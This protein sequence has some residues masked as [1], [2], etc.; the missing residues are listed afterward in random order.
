[1]IFGKG[2]CNVIIRNL[3]RE[4]D[5]TMKKHKCLE[6]SFLGIL[7]V[8]NERVIFMKIVE[9]CLKVPEYYSSFL[10]EF[11][12]I[13]HDQRYVG[14]F[15]FNFWRPH[16]GKMTITWVIRIQLRQF[17]M[18]RKANRN[19]YNL[20]EDTKSQFRGFKEKNLR[21]DVKQGQPAVE[22]PSLYAPVASCPNREWEW[23][24]SRM[25]NPQWDMVGFFPILINAAFESSFKCNF[26]FQLL[27]KGINDP[28]RS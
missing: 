8:S 24:A 16:F 13:S 23:Q 27:V 28:L 21:K 10:Y 19:I 14:P 3:I 18:N 12:W 4:Y 2:K 1:M 25:C 6:D 15:T 5:M 20:S 17:K 26:Q 22:G 7:K 9:D 11:M